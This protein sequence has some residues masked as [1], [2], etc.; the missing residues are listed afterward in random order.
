MI[1]NALAN[2]LGLQNERAIAKIG[3]YHGRDPIASTTKASFKIVSLNKG[4]SF[5]IPVCYSVPVL[6]IRNENV[7]LKKLVKDWPHL[8]SLKVPAKKTST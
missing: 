1:T 3:T 2:E 6:K 5:K 8:S 4:S 7:D